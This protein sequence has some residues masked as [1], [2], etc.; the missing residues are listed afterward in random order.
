M[1]RFFFSIAA[2]CSVAATA[3]ATAA[4]LRQGGKL[5]L[6][7]GISTVEG[8][9]GGGLTPWAVIAGNET[10]NGVG[11]QAS[12]N[13]VH[14]RDYDLRQAGIAIGLFD[15]VEVSLARQSVDTNKVGA[16]L[17]LGRD[18]RFE[19][20]IAGVKVKLAGDLIYGSPWLPAIAVGAH[21]KH[22]RNQAVVRAI[23]A[24]HH[25]GI[26]FYASATKLSLRQSL[27]LNGTF[28]LTKANQ[29][30][31]LGFGGE[32]RDT[33]RLQIE[34]SAA[35]Q[36]SRRLAIG[37]EYRAKPDNLAIARESDAYDVFAAY[38]L[39]RHATAT[40]A[41]ADLGSI[42]TRDGQRGFLLQLQGAF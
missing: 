15:R 22:S 32:G 5:L 36:L 25:E 21:Y 17:G 2:A 38:G 37:V 39:S 30:G 12:V 3:P 27:L 31:L 1:A 8:S 26:D 40:V 28:R 13:W 42:A 16:R 6:T 29:L 34:G 7:N 14:V 19:Q 18:Y 4:D 20:D 35:Y 9:A 11:A 24:A 33:Y 23:G 41:Y 10:R